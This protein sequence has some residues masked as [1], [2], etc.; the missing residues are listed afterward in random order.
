MRSRSSFGMSAGPAPDRFLV[1]LATLTLLAEVAEQ[2]P[3]V[4]VLDD[5]Q[6]LDQ[7]TVRILGFVGR[8]L[9]AERIAIVCAVRT[10]VGDDVL[11][12]LPELPLR[13][14]GDADSRALL[15]GSVRGPL[16]AAVRDQIISESRGNPLALIELPRTWNVADLAGG[17]GLPVS[18]PRGTSTIE[19][20]YVR[21]LLGLP[22][23]A[24]LLV[25]AAAAEPL[26]DPV[27]LYR[28]AK[29]LGLDA[30]S[31]DPAVDAGLLH[32]GGGVEFAHPLVRSAAY[33][34]A[35]ADDRHR[36]HRALAEATDPERDPDR[37][38]WHLARATLGPDEEVAAELERS[39]S[40]A[41]ARGGLA[42]AAAFL[43]RAT[44][45]T[46]EPEARARRAL[47][48]AQSKHLAGA[49]EAALRLLAIARAGPLE[50]ARRCPRAA[51]ASP[52]LVRHHPRPGCAPAAARHR[53]AARV[54]GSGAGA[55]DVPR[56]VRGGGLRGTAGAE[57]RRPRD[58]GGGARGGV[59]RPPRPPA[60]APATSSSTASR[61]SR[62]MDTRPGSPG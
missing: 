53:P 29:T 54:A 11:D 9:L 6:W 51:P 17:F 34:S 19:Q 44:E 33:R 2:E 21:R 30:A 7:A 40:R 49:P 25:L 13:G 18:R 23:N 35:D 52:D 62:P 4:C 31:A 10:G 15:E 45:L 50:R 8:R 46:P 59:G 26:G 22:P 32:V 42:A 41:Q 39:A 14:L 57:R 12:G 58:R 3:L 55:R 61:I 16:D 37:R 47:A 28:A 5:A 60:R 56:G 43:E 48:A 38:A 1:G 36:V 27:L 20:S 24:R